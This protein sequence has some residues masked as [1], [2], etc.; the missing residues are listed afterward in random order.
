M[1]PCFSPCFSQEQGLLFA[2]AFA[3]LAG[4][5]APQVLLCLPA[6]MGALGY[7]PTEF[8]VLM[9][10][11]KRFRPLSHSHFKMQTLNEDFSVLTQCITEGG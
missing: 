7:R 5:Q 10:A 8:Q 11:E 2:V 9:L 1:T 4:Q 3:R 6:P